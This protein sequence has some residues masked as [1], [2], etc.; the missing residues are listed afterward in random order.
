MGGYRERSVFDIDEQGGR[1]RTA[2][3]GFGRYKHD[4]L[5]A[6]ITEYGKDP[7][8][9]KEASDLP[10]FKRSEFL[11]LHSDGWL[12]CCKKAVCGKFA[13]WQISESALTKHVSL[14]AHGKSKATD[15]KISQVNLNDLIFERHRT[16]Y[17]RIA[18]VLEG[19]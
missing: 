13:K 6:L 12:R 16:E 8:T 7:F 18:D 11:K 17:S 3:R 14:P 2:L 1:M 5:I 10:V 4:L 9:Y 15:S 19:E